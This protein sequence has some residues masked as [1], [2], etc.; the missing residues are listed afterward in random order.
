MPLLDTPPCGGSTRRSLRGGWVGERVLVT[1]AFFAVAG[2]ATGVPPPE[3]SPPTVGLPPFTLPPTKL[4]IG[5]TQMP[6]ESNAPV[7]G[8]LAPLGGGASY[9]PGAPLPSAAPSQSVVD[10]ESTEAAL[11]SIVAGGVSLGGSTLESATVTVADS[12]TGI[13]ITATLSGTLDGYDEAAFKEDLASALDVD[14][15]R[16]E[17]LSVTSGS[18]VVETLVTNPTSAPTLVPT[19]VPTPVPPTPVPTPVPPTPVPTPVPPTPVPTP[20]P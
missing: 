19:P 17:V 11:N 4:Q 20:V 10:V 3:S 2:W 15:S 14:P 5:F 16:I 12:G 7:A 8:S 6:G 13:A 18:V 9:A 1:L